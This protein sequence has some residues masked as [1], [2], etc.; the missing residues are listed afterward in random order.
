[1]AKKSVSEVEESTE[2]VIVL[3]RCASINKHHKNTDGEL[4]DL[5]CE[6]KEGHAGDHSSDYL[7]YRPTDGSTKQAKRI[8]QANLEGKAITIMLGGKELIETVEKTYWSS[9]AEI[10]AA[11]IKPDLAQLA[12]IKATKGNMLD[13]AQILR[14]PNA[15]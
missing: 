3:S 5:Q 9:V 8:S 1:M 13:E 2:D 15:L 6:L 12:R 4:E 10:P 14:N 7:C 11:D